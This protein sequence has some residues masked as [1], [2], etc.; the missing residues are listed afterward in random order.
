MIKNTIFTQ[1]LHIPGPIYKFRDVQFFFQQTLFN[2]DSDIKNFYYKVGM[3]VLVRLKYDSEPHYF[4]FFCACQMNMYHLI[5][6]FIF[7]NLKNIHF[8]YFPANIVTTWNNFL[9]SCR[10]LFVVFALKSTVIQ[11]KC[12]CWKITESFSFYIH[13]I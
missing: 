9:N 2:H 7:C 11:Y 12:C 3:F 10:L 6:S 1:K 13:T 8:D 4:E 5:L